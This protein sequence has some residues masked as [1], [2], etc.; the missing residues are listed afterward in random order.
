LELEK[1][2]KKVKLLKDKLN[3]ELQ[4]KEDLEL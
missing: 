4:E 2:S 3:K 1:R